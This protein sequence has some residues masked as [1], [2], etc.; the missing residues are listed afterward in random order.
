M[1]ILV[2]FDVHAGTVPV[3]FQSEMTDLQCDFRNIFRCAPLIELN[4]SDYLQLNFQSCDDKHG[5][6]QSFSEALRFVNSCV[7]NL[8]KSL[9]ML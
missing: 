5:E 9:C 3:E 7:Q 1:Y 2:I 8:I 4:N 6:W